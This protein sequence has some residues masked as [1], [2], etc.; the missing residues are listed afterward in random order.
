M[1]RIKRNNIEV[2]EE[3]KD[4]KVIMEDNLIIVNN[5]PRGIVLPPKNAKGV[6][7]TLLPGENSVSREEWDFVKKNPAIKQFINVGFLEDKGVGK[8]RPI[9][10][11]LDGVTMEEAR[12]YIKRERTKEQLNKWVSGTTS[13]YLRKLCEQRISKL[14]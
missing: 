10:E 13:E 14:K 9:L 2:D 12:S 4:G 11:T 7:I 3:D 8:A 1:K 6:G 5:E